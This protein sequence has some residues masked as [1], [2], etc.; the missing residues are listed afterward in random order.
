MRLAGSTTPID[1]LA[2]DTINLRQNAYVNERANRL[3]HVALLFGS[4]RDAGDRLR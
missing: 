1:Y 4:L 2:V 3:L